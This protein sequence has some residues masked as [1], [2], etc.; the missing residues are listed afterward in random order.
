MLIVEDNPDCAELL[1]IQLD[2]AGYDVC[3]AGNAEE[4]LAIAGE[5]CPRTAIIDIG[6][7]GMDGYDLIEALLE[8]PELGAC[9]FFAVTG[10]D[11]RGFVQRS[12]DAGFSAHFTKP[13]DASALLEAVANPSVAVLRNAARH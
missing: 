7:P 2:N 3:V 6:L 4:A 1:R 9:R 8:K 11:G 12:R 10:Y 13:V 5:L